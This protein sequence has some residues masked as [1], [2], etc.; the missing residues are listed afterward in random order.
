MSRPRLLLRAMLRSMAL[1]Q[2]VCFNVHGLCCHQSQ[3]GHP[4]SMVQP[5]ARLMSVIRGT[6]KGLVLVHGPTAVRGHVHGL[7]CHQKPCRIPWSLPPLTIKSK[8]APLAVI[9]IAADAH[10]RT[11]NVESLC[12]NSDSP[13][14]TTKVTTYQRELLKS[15]MQKCSSPQLIT[16][17]RDAEGEGLL[18]I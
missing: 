7:R 6:S 13:N 5:K 8:E 11:R 2:L 10:L 14:S 16:F 17:R 1:L 18:F 3:S 4:W 9:S 15:V 12:N